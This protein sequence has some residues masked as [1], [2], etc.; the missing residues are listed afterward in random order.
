M[1]IT[2]Y[3]II[4]PILLIHLLFFTACAWAA[5][6]TVM[7]GQGTTKD[8]AIQD[9]IRNAVESATGVFVY[10]ASE[11]KDF[12][13]VRDQIVTASRGYVK[14]YKLLSES[15]GEGIVFVTL[16][17]SVDTAAIKS[18]IKR[19]MKTTT[20]EDALKDYSS[21]AS[22][23]ERNKKYAEILK[24]ISS[25]PLNEL[26]N[27]NFSGYE[28]VSAGTTSAD[29]ILKFN[30]T[31]NNFLWDTYYETLRLIGSSQGNYRSDN[32][33]IIKYSIVKERQSGLDI[34]GERIYFHNDFNNYI[35]N[36]RHVTVV[37][38]LPDGEFHLKPFIIYDRYID[39]RDYHDRNVIHIHLDQ[40]VSR[41]VSKNTVGFFMGN[42]GYIFKVRHT[43]KNIDDIK[44]LPSVKVTLKDV[45]QKNI[46]YK[47]N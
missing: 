26:Y 44:K 40:A 33:V 17:V 10:S 34:A 12:K 24:S 16:N 42:E 35:I 13:L 18:V 6:S 45:A 22:L 47:W 32:H 21:V 23:V 43:L 30:I 25:R 38:G 14:D 27:V 1:R 31:P 20:Y 19:D 39:K 15:K 28:I 36:P 3:F 7:T 9:A 2:K 41:K 37:C 8:E 5:N 29:V 4:F 11:V 46:T